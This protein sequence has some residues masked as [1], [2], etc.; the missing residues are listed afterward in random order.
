[1]LLIQCREYGLCHGSE[2]K[3]RGWLHL[4]W[5]VTA[6]EKALANQSVKFCLFA[7]ERDQD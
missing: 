4:G 6:D 2:G 3:R 5:Y 1:M 7:L